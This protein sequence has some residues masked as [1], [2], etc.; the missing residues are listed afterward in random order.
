[1]KVVIIGSS[2][3]GASLAYTLAK[4]GVNVEVYERKARKDIGKKVCANIVSKTF[5]SS[6]KDLEIN[7]TKK[8]FRNK[9]DKAVFISGKNAIEFPTRCY[10]LNRQVFLDI[11]IEKAMKKGARFHF[12][13][14]FLKFEKWNNEYKSYLRENNHIIAV[15]SDILVGADGTSSKVAECSGLKRRNFFI[16]SESPVRTDKHFKKNAWYVFLKPEFGYYAF[17]DHEY[18]GTGCRLGK[19]LGAYQKSFFSYLKIKPAKIVA[20]L[21]PEPGCI[22]PKDGLFLIGD[23]GGHV[24][25]NGGGIVPAIRSAIAARDIILRKD[26]K[27]FRRIRFLQ[28][29]NKILARAFEKMDED[30]WRNLFEILKD[31]KFQK[32]I[33][34]RD[35]ISIY[36]K[37]AVDPRFLRFIPKLF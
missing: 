6:L 19:N 10:K 2:I 29:I 36:E 8:L 35:E 11:L 25:F 28:F 15:N 1:M 20:A 37:V 4:S 14:E 22:K 24:K 30:D 12:K 33:E 26:Y 21:E 16:T 17:F 18:A 31:K 3:A 9:F 34:N 13:T 7:K 23:A 27:L 5:L 32:L